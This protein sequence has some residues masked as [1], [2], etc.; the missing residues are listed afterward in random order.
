MLLRLA[1]TGRLPYCRKRGYRTAKSTLPFK[2]LA[3]FK[4]PK[5]GMVELS[6]IEPLTSYI[7]N[8]RALPTE[9]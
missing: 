3:D 1:F 2:V 9:L 5:S 8:V 4:T 6:G 7:A